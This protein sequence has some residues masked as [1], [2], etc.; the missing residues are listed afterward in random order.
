MIVQDVYDEFCRTTG[1]DFTERISFLAGVCAA[2]Q[3][4]DNPPHCC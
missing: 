2:A 1:A 3:M 4:L